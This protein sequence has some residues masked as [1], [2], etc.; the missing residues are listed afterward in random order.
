MKKGVHGMKSE[1]V[2][3]EFQYYLESCHCSPRT[4]KTHGSYAK[5]FTGFLK[6]HY[7][8]INSLDRISE[9]VI[10]DFQSYLAHTKDRGGQ[11]LWNSIQSLIL[12]AVKKFFRF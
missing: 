5:R 7:P 2:V 12:R 4:V 10:L 9:D 6:E 8:R 3:K 1:N 11:C